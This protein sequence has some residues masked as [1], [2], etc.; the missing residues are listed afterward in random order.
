[1]K[2]STIF[3]MAIAITMI[4]S[5]TVRAES[6]T[7]DHTHHHT[8]ADMS[9]HQHK[10]HAPIGVMGDHTHAKGKWMLSYR[11]MHMDMTGNRSGTDRISPDTIATTL[12]NPFTG[13]ATVRVV[14]TSMTMDMHMVSGMYAPSDWLTVMLM[15]MWQQKEMEHITYAGMAG[16]TVLGTFTANSEGWGDTRATGLLRLYHTPRNNIHLN[17]GISVPTGSITE[18]GR[19]LAPTGANPVLRMPYAM[20]LGTGTYDLLP[21][22]TWNGNDGGKWSWGAQ[23]NAE[24]RLENKNDEGYAWGDKHQLT[25]WGAYQWAEWMNSSLRLT[26]ME[27]GDIDGNDP[28]IT[29]PVQTANPDNYGGQ[30][31]EAGLGVNF[32]IPRGPLADHRLAIEASVPLHRDVNGTQLERDWSVT[33]GW[34]YAF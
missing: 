23:Y 8:M 22:L 32:I 21:G 20:Q 16:T 12:L 6:S 10:T 13:P 18:R 30:T 5:L 1:M 25:G 31:F 15:G 27:Q 2:Q 7:T 26:A 33:V 17:L 14:P 28:L 4:L 3:V 9:S 11:Y 19:V 34:Q 29:A 24:V